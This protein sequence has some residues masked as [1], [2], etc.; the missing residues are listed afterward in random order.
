M[1]V[2]ITSRKQGNKAK[3]SPVAIV[4]AV[5]LAAAVAYIIL[6][7]G[8]PAVTPDAQAN[9]AAPTQAQ[10]PSVQVSSDAVT[11][12]PQPPN[13][14]PANQPQSPK[15]TSEPPPPPEAKATPM[16]SESAKTTADKTPETPEA[17]KPAKVFDNEVENQLELVSQ[18]G[19]SAF[20][21]PRVDMSEEEILAYLKKP[22]EIY[23]DD[24]ED[25]IAAKER[26]AEIKQEALKYIG[27]GGTLNQ[28][29]RD[30]AAQVKEGQETVK[31]VKDEMIRILHD[32][33][34]EAAQAY[35]NK[36]NPQLREAGLNEVRIGK[37]TLKMM[38]RRLA[39][40]AAQAAAKQDN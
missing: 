22:V 16:V 15:G 32:Q 10:T 40:E 39:K 27:Q 20:V 19:F 37:G 14:T 38:E 3:P 5:A 31:D 21:T 8:K 2:V 25:T 9:A 26:T 29:L 11:P 7:K 33:G 34:Q 1:A 23:D 17:A 35:L 28:F 24:D 18:D 6:G 12:V 13:P 36:M 30:Y 4:L